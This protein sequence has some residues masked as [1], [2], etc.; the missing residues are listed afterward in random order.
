MLRTLTPLAGFLAALCLI[1]CGPAEARA[2]LLKVPTQY[3]TIAEAVAAA[4]AGDTVQVASGRYAENL[5]INKALELWGA[6]D[7]IAPGAPNREAETV[8]APGAGLRA[9]AINCDCRV[10]VR[11]FTFEANGTAAIA[12]VGGTVNLTLLNNRFRRAAGR[13]GTGLILNNLTALSA[14]HNHFSG[15]AGDTA[16]IRVSRC[17]G[18]DFSRNRVDSCAMTGL[19][20][21][22][23]GGGGTNRIYRNVFNHIDSAGVA[24][25]TQSG[26]VNNLIIEENDFLQCNRSGHRE[27]GGIYADIATGGTGFFSIDVLSNRFTGGYNGL[28]FR[29][30]RSVNGAQW[31]VRYNLFGQQAGFGIYFA[32]TGSLDATGNWW[33]SSRGP[34]VDGNDLPSTGLRIFAFS[35]TAVAYSPWLSEHSDAEADTTGLQLAVPAV[36]WAKR[37]WYDEDV[38]ERAVQIA[39]AGDVVRFSDREFTHVHLTVNKNLTFRSTGASSPPHF[40]RL[41]LEGPAEQVE[42]RMEGRFRADS[43]VLTRGTGGRIETGT[44]TL[45]IGSHLS[46]DAGRAV[47]GYA[48]IKEDVGQQAASFGGIGLALSAG[49]DNMGRVTVT[50]AAG[51]VGVRTIAGSPSIARVWNLQAD[52]V[53]PAGK[54]EITLSWRPDGDNSV[55]LER[56]Q[57]WNRVSNTASW[58]TIGAA[59][60]LT[61]AADPRV[62]TDTITV[63][64][65]FTLARPNICRG[66]SV[67]PP[68]EVVRCLGDVPTSIN[69]F[70]SGGNGTLTYQWTP[71]DGL[72]TTDRPFT[73][74]VTNESRIYTVTVRDDSGCVATGQTRVLPSL[75]P[76]LL[77]SPPQSVCQGDSVRIEATGAADYYWVPEEG[78]EGSRRADPVV[79]PARTTT[80]S[81]VGANSNGCTDT[82]TVEVRVLPLPVVNAT[83]DTTLCRGRDTRLN[84]SSNLPAAR[85]VWE[86]IEGLANSSIASPIAQPLRTITY[87]AT[88]HTLDGCKAS[89][90]VRVAV[91]DLPKASAGADRI[92]CRGSRVQL[93]ATGGVSYRWEPRVNIVNPDSMNPVVDPLATT[94]YFVTVTDSFGCSNTASALVSVVNNPV[95]SAFGDTLVCAGDSARL[96]AFGGL[97]Y[98]WTPD[99]GIDSIRVSSPFAAPPRTT[100]YTVEVRDE[101]GCRS[102]DSVLVRVAALPQI[103]VDAPEALCQDDETTLKVVS[104]TTLVEYEWTPDLWLSDPFSGSPTARPP[105]GVNYDLR[106][107]DVNGCTAETSHFL[108]VRRRPLVTLGGNRNICKGGYTQFIAGGGIAYS[109]SPRAGLSDPKVFNPLAAPDTTTTYTVTVTNADGCSSQGTVTVNVLAPNQ[110]IIEPGDYISLCPQGRAELRAPID[111]GFRYQWYVNGSRIPNATGPA[112]NAREIGRYSVEIHTIEGCTLRSAEVVVAQ[113]PVPNADAGPTTYVC[114]SGDGQRL[115]GSGGAVYRWE[116]TEGLSAN[117]TPTPLANP[118][119]TTTYTL[120]IADLAGCTARDTVTV[121]VNDPPSVNLVADGPTAFC[122]GQGVV[123]RATGSAGSFYQ[124]YLNGTELS[125]QSGSTLDVI[126]AGQYTVKATRPG[127]PPVETPPITVAVRPTP[128]ATAGPEIILCES[129]SGIALSGKATGGSSDSY[130]FRWAP[131]RGLSQ[132][133]IANP[134]ARPE[135][136]TIYTLTVTDRNGCQGMASVRVLVL[137]Q[138][139]RPVINP[140]DVLA[141]C[142]GDT[143]V[144]STDSFPGY[145][146]QWR[147]EGVLIGT[148]SQVTIDR[149]G[150]Y[151]VSVHSEGCA[152]VTSIAKGVTVNPLPI[153]RVEIRPAS[154]ADCPDGQILAFGSDGTGDQRTYRYSLDGENFYE[155]NQFINLTPGRYT[156]WVSDLIG[157]R[158][159]LSATVGVSTGRTKA[160][161]VQALQ[162]YPNPT[163][164]GFRLSFTLEASEPAA[165]LSLRDALGREVWSEVR[166]ALSAG[167]N[168][169][170]V[171]LPPSLT[172]GVYVIEISGRAFTAQ[173]KLILR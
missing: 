117:D 38:A 129:S 100:T 20:I 74:T 171:Q 169:A 131:E 87:T 12:T 47:Y 134:L 19:Y 91:R 67:N 62:F 111:N 90:T 81:V 45:E 149:S 109:W 101:N 112:F 23:L 65:E 77:A 157:C 126:R 86:P 54:R 93:F 168:E 21:D 64:G 153:V 76:S 152:Q 147:R 58:T 146:F 78:L 148:Q 37:A 48:E 24:L 66:L 118:S 119:R 55:D 89:D 88:V 18:L 71:E 63:L 36:F 13:N 102:R 73:Q 3:A 142:I 132:P 151:S 95:A 127:C 50:R 115:R 69:A 11:G 156:V 128:R 135:F 1:L 39:R 154:C 80:Y 49:P 72:L 35:E 170:A 96:R 75:K 145:R 164:G 16:A 94:R 44:D 133:N 165:R 130:S 34:T 92:L 84:V 10:V 113:Q 15:L 29:T 137:D 83:K 166:G 163:D 5:V 160:A 53:R 159:S 26:D 107:R 52:G 158:D 141:F 51:P 68:L 106:V 79:S 85:Y 162:L 108:D 46:E 125:D 104:D 41:T 17:G 173:Q 172:P 123:L 138:L 139:P 27:A 150:V 9:V 99:L 42:L 122:E 31:R 30:G 25:S 57:L 6:N 110:P 121:V 2:A 120:T 28:A 167:R 8:I 22:A 40:R 32:S 103:R 114:R 143:R 61:P 4:A 14:K 82:A 124:W 43:V 70:A 144:L 33:N 155:A 59:K 136:T 60:N 161:G 56:V 98:V 105:G 116:P 140:R 7:T 97:T